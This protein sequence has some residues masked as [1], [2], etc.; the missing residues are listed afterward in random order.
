MLPAEIPRK[1]HLIVGKDELAQLTI[2]CLKRIA[3]AP[4]PTELPQFADAEKNGR[5]MLYE[6]AYENKEWDT[7]GSLAEGMLEEGGYV[8]EGVFAIRARYALAQAYISSPGTIET[9]QKAYTENPEDFESYVAMAVLKIACGQP[10]HAKEWIEIARTAGGGK[11]GWFAE[12]ENS[13]DW[14]L[15]R[16]TYHVDCDREWGPKKKEPNNWFHSDSNHPHCPLFT[17]LL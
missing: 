12:L 3:E 7:L 6:F 15:K 4:R 17:L 16:G 8:E 14:S 2:A 10:L 9:A 5:V 11:E 13:C 1:A